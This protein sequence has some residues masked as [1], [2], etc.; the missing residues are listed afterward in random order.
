M[1][2]RMDEVYRTEVADLPPRLVPSQAA[3]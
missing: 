2:P 1:T 3:E